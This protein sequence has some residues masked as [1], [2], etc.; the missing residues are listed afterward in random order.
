MERRDALKSLA[1]VA[2]GLTFGS[3]NLHAFEPAGK[4]KKY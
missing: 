2:G 1:M 4:S 3:S